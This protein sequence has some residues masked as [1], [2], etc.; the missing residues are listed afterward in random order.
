MYPRQ[1]VESLMKEIPACLPV[2]TPVV[3]LTVATVVS[4]LSHAVIPEQLHPVTRDEPTHTY[5]VSRLPLTAYVISPL[6]PV[7]ELKG[8]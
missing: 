2:I 1:Q 5:S 3:G 4:E 6:I 8:V 7:E